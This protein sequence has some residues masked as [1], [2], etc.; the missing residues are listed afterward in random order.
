MSEI[1]DVEMAKEYLSYDP[2]TGV[3][4]W[5]K[6]SSN[7]A[8]VGSVAGCRDKR[9]NYIVIRLNGVLF[10]DQRLACAMSGVDIEGKVVDHINGDPSD[11]RLVNLRACSHSENMKNLSSHNDNVYSGW[12]GVSK[13]P[14]SGKWYSRI[15]LDGKTLYLGSFSDEREAA[16]AYLFAALEHSGEYARFA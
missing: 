6:K 11:N 8:V 12:K 14:R 4:R 10:R 2:E 15:H 13:D 7:R 1:F 16:E 9:H 3:F 5:I